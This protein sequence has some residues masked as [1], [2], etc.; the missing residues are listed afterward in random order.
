M[1]A[2]MVPH[3][4]ASGI[5]IHIFDLNKEAANKIARAHNNIFVEDS[6]KDVAKVTDAVITMLPAGPEVKDCRGNATGLPHQ[7]TL[8]RVQRA[9]PWWW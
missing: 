1:G 6:A 3:I 2:R 4:A 9:R 8:L 5:P 7:E